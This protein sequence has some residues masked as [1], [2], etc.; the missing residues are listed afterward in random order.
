M[1]TIKLEGLDEVRAALTEFSDRRFAAAV[2]TS[3]TRSAKETSR[4]WQEHI[5]RN[6]DRPIA[7]TRA[8]TTFLSASAASLTATVKVKDA[9]PGTPPSE[10]LSPQERAGSRTMKKFEAALQASGAMPRGYVTVPGRA[11]VLDA[12]GNVS[13]AQIVAVIAALGKDWSPGYQRV[14]GSTTERRLARQQKL[15]RKYIAIQPEEVAQRRVSGGIY[16]RMA[17]G[18][19]RAVF[20]YRR[21]VSYRKRLDLEALAAKEAPDIIAEEFQRAVAESFARL[22]ARGG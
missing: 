22:R 20:V 8:A 15:G 7:R 16:E 21:A 5:N 3:F 10:Y 13:R 12:Y 14:I 17:D 2:A 6:L 4:S 18:T 9:L 1:L 11:A 19:L